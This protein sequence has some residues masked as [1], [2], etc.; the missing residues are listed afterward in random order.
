VVQLGGHLMVDHVSPDWKALT[1]RRSLGLAIIIL[2]VIVLF[3]PIFVGE[4]VIAVLGLLLIAAGLFQ[5]VETR[6]SSDRTSSYL[7]YVA[8][9]VTVL[10]GFVLF[11]SPNL[12]LSGLLLGVSIF[13]LIDGGNKVVAAYKQTGSERWWNLFNGLFTIMLGL[14]TWYFLSARI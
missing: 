11:L 10:L 8:G 4:W 14:M 7:S 1:K 3:L 9:I 12:V 5:F 13:F 6:R 2:G